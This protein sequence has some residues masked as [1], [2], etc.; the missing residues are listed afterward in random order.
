MAIFCWLPPE[1]AAARVHRARS[2][3][4]MRRKTEAT[5]A[6]SRLR[7]MNPKRQNRSIT[8]MEALTLPE[9]LRN[10]ASVLRSSGTRLMPISART[11]STG[12]AI[13]TGFS[14]T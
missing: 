13:T 1:N 12:E 10:S 3:T 14:S 5:A 11:A 6:F 9:S 7:S 4:S 8:G 2:A